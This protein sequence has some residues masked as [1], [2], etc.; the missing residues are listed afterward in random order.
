MA[1]NDNAMGM[2]KR[3][4]R[5]FLG[6]KFHENAVKANPIAYLTKEFPPVYLMTSTGDFLL[7]QAPVLADKLDA[8]GVSYEYK[9]YGTNDDPLPHVFHCNIKTTDAK[10]C[11]DEETAFFL[12]Q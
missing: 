11:N 3:L 12:K 10:I 1:I 7:N 6:K 2:M 8:L 5:D 9:I 4:M